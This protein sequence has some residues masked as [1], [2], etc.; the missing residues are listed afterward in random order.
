VLRPGGTLAVLEAAAPAPGP[1]APFHG[2]YLRHVVP[3]AGRL[4]SDPSAYAYLSRSIFE[5]GAGPE[6]ETAL[7]AAHFRIVDR[8]RFLFGA[9]R[10]WVAERAA[11]PGQELSSTRNGRMQ[12]ARPEG[13]NGV[14]VPIRGGRV[15]GE[16][17]TWTGV[18]LALAVALTAAFAQALAIL[19]NS[20]GDLPL[21]GW[22]RDAAWLLVVG[23]LVVFGLRSLQLLVRLL[24]ARPRP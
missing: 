12:N 10:L 15:T 3:L 8:Q 16:W 5:F 2:F 21:T 17:R 14:N 9:T 18:Q 4:S 19:V 22:Q 24:V 23:G 1:F 7:A 11:G 13:A 20:R 6:F